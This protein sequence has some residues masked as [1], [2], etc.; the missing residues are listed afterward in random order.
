MLHAS[1][2][3]RVTTLSGLPSYLGQVSF[4][5]L[6]SKDILSRWTFPLVPDDNH[7]G[8]H[9]YQ[10]TR[11]NKYVSS[12]VTLART[13]RIGNNTLIGASTKIHD[14]AQVS[15]SVIG[16]N[17][18]IG[19]GSIVEGAYIFDGTVIGAQCTVRRSI[20]GAGV[21]IRDKTHIERGCVV[22]D[23]VAVGPSASVQ[24]F[25]RLSKR[26]GES[27]DEEGNEEGDED[28]DLED[29]EASTCSIS[30]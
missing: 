11:G 20:I 4:Q 5:H 6:S 15:G 2:T 14:D 26:K 17:C 7:P 22:G 28:S 8:G 25:E 30:P 19:A 16:R 18:V 27:S 23:G 29:I 1:R 12:E 13:C 10:H 21:T 24:P 9:V 3:Q